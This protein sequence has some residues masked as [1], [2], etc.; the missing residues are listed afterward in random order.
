MNTPPTFRTNGAVGAL[1]DEYEKA[2]NELLFVINGVSNDDLSKIVD[3]ITSDEDCRSIQTIL[4]HV[5]SSGYTYAVEVRR[6]LGEEE[7][8]REK[9]L[10]STAAE[11]QGALKKMFQYNVQLFDNHP[12]LTLCEHDEDQKIT[13]RWGQKYD[14]EQL[15]EHAIVHVLRHR[16]QIERFKLSL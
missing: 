1:L 7:Q 5:V 12:D 11:Y 8:Y 4:A 6:W 15:F 16:R 9:V 13:V 2:L 3:T 14:V 10:L